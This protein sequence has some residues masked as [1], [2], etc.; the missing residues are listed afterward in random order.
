[1]FGIFPLAE[2]SV[3]YYAAQLV[4]ALER[5]HAEGIL[6]RSL[7]PTSLM[8]DAAGQL[9]VVGLR[10]SK[11]VGRGRTFT[12]CGTPEYHSGETPLHAAVKGGHCNIVQLLV[13]ARADCNLVNKDKQTPMTLAERLG[14]DDVQRILTVHTR[15]ADAEL[16]SAV[17]S[18]DV[19]G[20]Q[21]LLRRRGNPNATNNVLNMRERTLTLTLGVGRPNARPNCDLPLVVAIKNGRRG[22]A[23]RIFATAHKPTCNVAASELTVDYS[24]RL[25]QGGCGAVYKAWWRGQA[26]AV[27]TGLQAQDVGDL[28]KEIRAM[29]AYV[30]LVLV[31]VAVLVAT[32]GCD[33]GP[34][35]QLVLEYMDGGDLRQYLD[36]KR[37]SAAVPVEYSPL[38]VAW[39][40]AN[41]LA[42]LHNCGLMHRDL[43]SLNVL[44]SSTNYIKVADL[45]PRACAQRRDKNDHWPSWMAPEVQ[46][47]D[48]KYNA[49]ADIY[50]FGVILTEL[51]TLQ[52][53]YADVKMAPWTLMT[54]VAAGRLRPSLHADCPAWLR[55]LATAC[56][57]HDPAQR[58]NAYDIVQKLQRQRRL[59]RILAT[60]DRPVSQVPSMNSSIPCPACGAVLPLKDI[61][62]QMCKTPAPSEATKLDMLLQ[63][64]EASDTA[65]STMLNCGVCNTPAS[66]R[67]EVCRNRD[68]GASYPSI[69]AK[70]Q[71]LCSRINVAN[72]LAA[73]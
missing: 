53:P 57:T 21:D 56:I 66:I 31:Y 20:L 14:L 52:M 30:V 35:V 64:I 34:H 61:M 63:R 1:D 25:G 27:K 36:K 65:I 19:H 15:P 55:E 39:V 9:A 71:A 7:D 43:K 47:P 2:S 46:V 42:D 17:M 13:D 24:C 72:K 28:E 58:P 40:I 18:R 50:S 41:A 4:L 26:V 23:K 44:L 54:E 16:V 32:A 33:V 3:R 29:K 37:D 5:F 49:S 11:Y 68:C 73:A 62:C 48:A 8:V 70:I 10:H 60:S 6:C 45:G 69:A 22:C 59:E 51:N 12:I 38:E 67:E